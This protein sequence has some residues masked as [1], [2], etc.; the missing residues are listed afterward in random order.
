MTDRRRTIQTT[1][2]L[3]WQI[4]PHCIVIVFQKRDRDMKMLGSMLYTAC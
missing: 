2:Q 4:T 3:R 1:K